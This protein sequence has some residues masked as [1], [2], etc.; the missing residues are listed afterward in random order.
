MSD[1]LDQTLGALFADGL[2]EPPPARPVESILTR[3]RAHERTR[4]RVLFAI[5]ALLTLTLGVLAAPWVDALTLA[6]WDSAAPYVSSAA[7]NV[8]DLVATSPPAFADLDT[9]VQLAL[10][11]GLLA[12][13]FLTLAFDEV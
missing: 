4:R 7:N 13:P 1:P 11:A 8:T 12:L 6:L 3:V 2:A 5:G 10:V 9:G